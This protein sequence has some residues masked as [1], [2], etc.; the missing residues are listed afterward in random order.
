MAEAA[1]LSRVTAKYRRGALVVLYAVWGI[2]A[3]I[4]FVYGKLIFQMLGPKAESRFV[5]S[6]GIGIGLNQVQEA[7]DLLSSVLQVVLAMTVLEMLWVLTNAR[8]LEANADYFSVHASVARNK[9]RKWWQTTRAY[10]HFYKGVSG[11]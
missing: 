4:I 9:G 2:F 10:S 7:R 1:T 11:S 3:W 5:E 8:W 6:W